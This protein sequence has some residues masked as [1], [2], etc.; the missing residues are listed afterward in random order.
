MSNSGGIDL[1]IN[2][3]CDLFIDGRPIEER[4]SLEPSDVERGVVLLVASRVV[5][6]LHPACPK[7][8]AESQPERFGLVG[9]S[10][11]IRQVR[12]EISRV[13][14]LDVP[15]LL[16]SET[17]TGKELV[18]RAIHQASRRREKNFLSL[19]M[20]ALPVNLASAELFGSV[21]GAY[22]GSVR[23]QMGYFFRAHQGSLFLDEIGAAPGEVQVMLLR[24]LE[25]GELQRVGSQEP[26]QVD[27]RLIAATDSDLEAAIKGGTFREPLLHRLAGY[28][29]SIPPLRHRRDDF[30]RLFFH[31]L[32][33]ELQKIGAEH[34]LSELQ[35]E[36]PWL[37]ASIV[38]RLAC[39]RWP[40]NVRQLRNVARQLVIASRGATSVRI[41][42]QLEKILREA[43][44]ELQHRQQ[45]GKPSGENPSPAFVPAP[46]A[47]AKRNK[48]Y[49]KPGEVSEEE[50]KI[51]LRE[52]RWQLK[53][54]A[55][56]LGVSRPSLYALIEKFPS[57]R[58]AGDLSQE[59]ILATK[60]LCGDNLEAIAD[61]LEVSRGGLHL[62]MKELELL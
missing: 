51:A 44:A 21:K 45:Q 60:E 29:I 22:T 42:P 38:A 43:E 10:E 6:L 62:K 50:L 17:G 13:A 9:D 35:G 26:Q 46:V 33:L 54:T 5:L 57:I 40:G 36:Q 2:N 23:S 32:R 30:G 34:R 58:K 39:H 31:F 53:P 14:D 3:D 15:V 12:E 55:A 20:G 49:R 7:A 61:H 56:Q 28:E 24:V 11:G 4:E 16:R 19:N 25:T 52:N 18:A 27:V 1:Q 37:P 47:K 41:T 8:E 48:T 59:E